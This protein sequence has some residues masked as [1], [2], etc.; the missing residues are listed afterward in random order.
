MASTNASDSSRNVENSADNNMHS[1]DLKV[2]KEIR[3]FCEELMK[4]DGLSHKQL[5]PFV[6]MRKGVIKS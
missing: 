2:G 3:E 6:Y 1:P 5:S 4:I